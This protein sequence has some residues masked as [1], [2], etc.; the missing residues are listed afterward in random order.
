MKRKSLLIT[1]L[2]IV[3]ACMSMFVFTAC[4]E[5]EHV[6]EWGA[7]QVDV[8][9][10][11]LAEGKEVRVCKLDASH[12][13]E[14]IT[15]KSEHSGYIFCGDC[16]KIL[17]SDEDTT[18]YNTL[19]A[20]VTSTDTFGLVI[21]DVEVSF[22]ALTDYYY[23]TNGDGFVNEQDADEHSLN[24][25]ATFGELVFGFNQEGDLIG[26]GKGAVSLVGEYLPVNPVSAIAY[27]EGSV[28]YFK[29]VN[30]EDVY[31]QVDATQ[32]MQMASQM[33]SKESLTGIINSYVEELK[34]KVPEEYYP[35]IDNIMDWINGD[36]ALEIEGFF[37]EYEATLEKIFA[38]SIAP[39]VKKTL[40]GNGYELTFNYDLLR[41]LN[42]NLYSKTIED[43]LI[44]EYGI[45][46]LVKIRNK[47]DS[48]LSTPIAQLVANLETEL[49]ITATELINKIWEEFKLPA[50]IEGLDK[51]EIIT[52]L[53][54]ADIT[55]N[56][57]IQLALIEEFGEGI[58]V[59]DFLDQ[60]FAMF[61]TM[62][63]Y[64]VY[65]LLFLSASSQPDEYS[66]GAL[67]YATDPSQDQV[68]LLVKQ[69]IDEVI[70]VYENILNVKILTDLDGNFTKLT[71]DLNI[72]LE[73]IANSISQIG[74]VDDVDLSVLGSISLIPNYQTQSLE[75]YNTFKTE[76]QE[77]FAKIDLSEQVMLEQLKAHYG[78]N[79]VT[80]E[81]G[82]YVIK[83]YAQDE[84][85]EEYE[86]QYGSESITFTRE[87]IS[88]N[89]TYRLNQA[90]NLMLI[91]LD[92][93]NGVIDL[94][95][96]CEV[97][98][99]EIHEVYLVT[100]DSQYK[101]LGEDYITTN[102]LPTYEEY[103]AIYF[104]Y[105]LENKTL[106]FDDY[107]NQVYV[108]HDYKIDQEKSS[109][110]VGEYKKVCYKCAECGKEIYEYVKVED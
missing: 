101:E 79:N 57:L 108:G 63:D 64:T 77:F 12:K 26:Y 33:L 105:D 45:N 25:T 60:G 92:Q 68:T 110:V 73:Q 84:Y 47:I 11:C 58:T 49:G 51:G 27:F 95:V 54:A 37:T 3:V 35:A 39:I 50:E 106:T 100:M 36:A 23:D 83:E 52:L 42:S 8:P 29:L 103:W 87:Y 4:G 7:W 86:Y 13:E 9:A 85:I 72:E 99:E 53:T 17:V 40:I 5:E 1:L 22:W 10:T 82:C 6:H 69:T 75:E 97:E 24:F 80:L 65:E 44:E 46:P 21:E 32:L 41:Q 67:V 96:V 55:P 48:I 107:E 61:E 19:L 88:F 38:A 28:G 56:S 34:A 14:R 90:N 15:S 78:E 2:A 76:S 59:K 94:G 43:Y 81:D 98:I 104:G 31:L 30:Y 74:D 16:A 89:Y 91:C 70:G 93:C 71:Y 66:G 62:L 109:E 102:Y 20:N 18:Y